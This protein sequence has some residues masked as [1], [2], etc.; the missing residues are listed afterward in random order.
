VSRTAKAVICRE[1]NRPVVVEQIEVDSPRR[2]EIMIRVA[3]CGVCHSDYSATDGT[4]SGYS[5]APSTGVLTPLSGSPFAIPASALAVN[6]AGGFL[7]ASD[8]AGTIQVF[9]IDSASGALTPISGSPFPG[10]AA[11]VLAY[12][13]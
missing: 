3:A 8:P 10:V 11:T 7:Y 13:Q 5:I 4:I 6:S 12:V 2:D 9:T 1:L